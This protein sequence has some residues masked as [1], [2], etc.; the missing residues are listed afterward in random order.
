MLTRLFSEPIIQMGWVGEDVYSSST[1]IFQPKKFYNPGSMISLKC[2][3]RRHLIKNTSIHDITNVSWKKNKVLI[4]LQEQERIRKVEI[5]FQT[6]DLN[7]Q[8][9]STRVAVSS[10]EVKST[11]LISDAV[12]ED[13][14]IYS[15]T[16]PVLENKDFPRARVMV[17][18]IYGKKYCQSFVFY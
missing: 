4:D 11:L 16:L 17:H 12:L 3:I 13:A 2:I 14:C 7:F 5:I 8:H 18:I 1:N 15:C 6:F 9:C 10:H